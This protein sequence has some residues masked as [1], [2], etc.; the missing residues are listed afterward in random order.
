MAT[1]TISRTVCLIFPFRQV[2]PRLIRILTAL[3]TGLILFQ[4]L[5]PFWYEKTYSYNKACVQCFSLLHEI[6]DPRS[7]EF[8]VFY[9]CLILVEYCAPI[10]PILASC[11]LSVVKLHTCQVPNSSSG[12]A[13]AYCKKATATVT[14]ILFTLLY[15]ICNIPLVVYELVGTAELY[16]PT[17]L[18]SFDGS[19]LYFRN[20]VAVHM[21]A[22]NA[23]ANCTLYF[24]RISA[25]RRWCVVLLSRCVMRTPMIRWSSPRNKVAS[26]STFSQTA[27]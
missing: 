5:V 12:C 27:L 15:L 16:N 8:I 13:S 10:V 11:I 4:A 26:A 7:P 3:Y 9:A 2:K 20:F 19:G 1:L 22:I 24:W 25:I 21:V 14:V 23:V 18:L 6:F 17:G